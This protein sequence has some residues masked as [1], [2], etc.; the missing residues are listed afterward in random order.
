MMLKSD[1]RDRIMTYNDGRYMEDENLM[2]NY[3]KQIDPKEPLWDKGKDSWSNLN[4]WFW[5]EPHTGAYVVPRPPP[6][7]LRGRGALAEN[8]GTIFTSAGFNTAITFKQ[9]KKNYINDYIR[10]KINA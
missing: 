1:K 10:N 7:D 8:E 9:R 2:T 6:L 4:K 3:A 5:K